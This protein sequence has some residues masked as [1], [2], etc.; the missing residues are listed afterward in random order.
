[1]NHWLWIL[2]FHFWMFYS[3]YLITFSLSIWQRLLENSDILCM[4]FLLVHILW[5][6]WGTPVDQWGRISFAPF[7]RHHCIHAFYCHNLYNRLHHLTRD[8]GHTYRMQCLRFP[9]K[10]FLCLG[11]ILAAHQYADTIAAHDERLHSWPTALQ[12]HVWA[13]S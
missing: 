12:F 5:H 1:M 9:L 13:L 8:R 2:E 11:I 6:F 3:E 10:Y 7:P 4:C